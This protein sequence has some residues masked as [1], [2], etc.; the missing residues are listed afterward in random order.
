MCHTSAISLYAVFLAIYIIL[1][2]FKTAFLRDVFLAG[3]STIVPFD[4]VNVGLNAPVN[5]DGE[6][7]KRSR[8]CSAVAVH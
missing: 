5:K 4:F 1:H 3:R 8:E 6:K 2:F 7:E